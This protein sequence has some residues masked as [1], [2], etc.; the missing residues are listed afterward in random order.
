MINVLHVI[1]SLDIGGTERQLALSLT[2]LDPKRVKSSVCYLHSPDDVASQIREMGIPVYNLNSSGRTQWLRAVLKLTQLV[3]SLEIDLIHTQLFDADLVGGVTG[4]IAGVPVI[5]TLANTAYDQ[6]W[7]VD[8]PNLNRLKLA[9]PTA[10]RKLM[11]RYLHRRVVAVSHSV[12]R[13][14]LQNMGVADDKVTVIH[15][16]LFPSWLRPDSTD[17]EAPLS[18][19]AIDPSLEG[20]YPI[21]LNTG[22]LVPQKGQRYLIE[23]MPSIRER[24]PNAVLLIAG[25][26]SLRQLLAAKADKL[27]IVNQVKFLGKRTDVKDLLRISDVFAFPSLYEG[28]PNALLEAMLMGVPCVASGIS[29]VLEVTKDGRLATVV[30]ARNPE[31]LAEGIIST[32]DNIESAKIMA[33]TA[34]DTVRRDFRIELVAEKLTRLYEECLGVS[35]EA[36]SSR[37][38]QE[39]SRIN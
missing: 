16:A 24:Y 33:Q 25:E 5:S 29:P 38:M 34:S 4:R 32:L 1:D 20:R 10:A 30:P 31:A 18:S 28:C 23:A 13:G 9:F 12:K 7:L 8:N 39:G 17:E 21:I 22:R 14:V 26:G 37:S 15:R 3:K 19:A 11:A 2:A 6:E 35:T 36:E 27:G